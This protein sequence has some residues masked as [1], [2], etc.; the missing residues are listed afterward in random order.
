MKFLIIKGRLHREKFKK[1]ETRYIVLKSL[2][3]NRNLSIK[4]RWEASLLLSKLAKN[5]SKT[6]IKN[7][8]FITGRARSFSR[9]FHLSRIQLRDL[10]RN[11]KL[12]GITK[13]S[14]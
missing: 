12:S 6:F 2:I 3:H 5:S 4:Y 1:F 11:N 8:C 9:F 13:A 14:W 7:R 10:A